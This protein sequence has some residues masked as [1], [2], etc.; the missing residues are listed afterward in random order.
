[1]SVREGQD[2]GLQ[3]LFANDNGVYGSNIT[4]D[5]ARRQSL[6]QLGDALIPR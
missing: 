1:M 2:L 3:W 6:S 4:T 5:Q